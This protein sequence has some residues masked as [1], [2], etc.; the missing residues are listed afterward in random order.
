MGNHEQ[1]APKLTVDPAE[2]GHDFRAGGAV[3]IAGGLIRYDD[4]GIGHN[5]AGYGHALFLAAAHLP[6]EVI[7][8]IG[9]ARQLERGDNLPVPLWCG[10]IMEQQG[11]LNVLVG[12]ENGN[13]VVELKNVPHMRGAPLCQFTPGE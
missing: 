9:N 5:G 11:K 13:E 1:S 8:P 10:E 2:Q 3:Q 6:G 12:R 7:M 4:P